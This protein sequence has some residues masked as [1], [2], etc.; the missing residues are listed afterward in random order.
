MS[1]QSVRQIALASFATYL[2]G[3]A[4]LS[5]GLCVNM[6]EPSARN[7]VNWLLKT[8]D[9]LSCAALVGCFGGAIC[10]AFVQEEEKH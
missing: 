9:G 7:L 8:G 5:V 6:T 3:M 4:L 1:P 10:A 2:V